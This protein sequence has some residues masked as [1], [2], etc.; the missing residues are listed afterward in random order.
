MTYGKTLG[1]G[2]PVGAVCAAARNLMK[3][4]RDDRPADICFA[5]GTFNSHPYVMATMDQFLTRLDAP[6]LANVYEGLDEMWNGRAAAL[7]ARLAA[8]EPA[9]TGRQSLV[10]LDGALYAAVPIQLDASILSAFAWVGAELDRK[11]APDL[12][13]EL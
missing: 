1:G 11:R 12:Q 7:N 3:R 6:A 4:F 9:G 13:P 10:D 8:A 5:R 2:L